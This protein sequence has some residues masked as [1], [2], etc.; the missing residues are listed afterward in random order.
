MRMRTVHLL[1]LTM[2]SVGILMLQSCDPE[3]EQVL[4]VRG[5]RPVYTQTNW[6]DIGVEA[7]HPISQLGKLALKDGYLFVNERLKGIHVIDNRDPANPDPVAFISIPG[8]TDFEFKGD[9][10]YADNFSDLLVMR[11]GPDFTIEITDRLEGLY[12]NELHAYPGHHE[13]YFECPDPSKGY[14]IDWI[15]ADLVNPKCRR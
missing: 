3:T 12:K 9:V 5:L 4:S 1:H 15:E 6:K 8:N 14:V 7:A 10:L 2:I 11:L 13:G